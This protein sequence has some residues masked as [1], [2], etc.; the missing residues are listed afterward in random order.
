[1]E[2]PDRSAVRENILL[3]LIIGFGVF[4]PILI[5]WAYPMSLF[6][7][8]GSEAAAGF[9][10]LGL[11]GVALA[12]AA[13]V[14]PSMVACGKRHPDAGPI[15]IVNILLGWTFVGWVVAL[16]WACMNK[17]Q[18]QEVVHIHHHKEQEALADAPP[19]AE[20]KPYPKCPPEL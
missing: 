6:A 8:D 2:R 17:V 5:A 14:F 15:A 3:G 9:C 12:I 4:L 20:A 7:A 13:Y 16:A 11:F 1:M 10:G 18:P 19:R